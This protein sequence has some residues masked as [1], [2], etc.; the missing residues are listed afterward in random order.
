M[1]RRVLCA[2]LKNALTWWATLESLFERK[3]V[4]PTGVPPPSDDARFSKGLA[5]ASL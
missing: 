1:H 4:R 3:M 2:R 5:G